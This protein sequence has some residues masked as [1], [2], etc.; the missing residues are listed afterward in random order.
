MAPMPARLTHEPT[1]AEHGHPSML[2][3]GRLPLGATT[4]TAV[5]CILQGPH[6]AAS[7][8]HE[9]GKEARTAAI[10][11][12]LVTRH[13]AMTKKSGAG[14]FYDVP[15]I[16][17]APSD[18]LSA[19]LRVHR[20]ASTKLVASIVLFASGDSSA[21]KGMRNSSSPILGRRQ[22]QKYNSLNIRRT[23]CIWPHMFAK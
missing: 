18:F 9:F 2:K 14:I 15:S 10:N 21:R 17:P 1:L 5:A 20:S 12:Q 8:G 13:V 22:I 6:R 11:D 3:F 23:C 19:W 7:A 16:A 4:S